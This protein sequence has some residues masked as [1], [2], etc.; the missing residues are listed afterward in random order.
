MS[1]LG[2]C[3]HV[4][5]CDIICTVLASS[6]QS[7]GLSK[8]LENVMLGPLLLPTRFLWQS[9]FGLTTKCLIMFENVCGPFVAHFWV[10]YVFMYWRVRGIVVL[11]PHTGDANIGFCVQFP[12]AN[13]IGL[14]WMRCQHPSKPPPRRPTSSGQQHLHLNHWQWSLGLKSWGKI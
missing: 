14:V 5:I 11:S 8:N 10:E 4:Q 6:K 7:I 3:R 13:P 12:L 1:I 2:T 9:F